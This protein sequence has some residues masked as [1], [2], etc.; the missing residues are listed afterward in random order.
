ML[1]V[2]RS[3]RSLYVPLRGADAGLSQVQ[4]GWA[5]T[6]CFAVDSLLIFPSGVAMDR[7]AGALPGGGG[8]GRNTPARY[9][10]KHAP[11]MWAA[12]SDGV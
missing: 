2:L 3:V 10:R 5:V 6:I 1:N 11:R 12:A 4:V 9:T 8:S 7:R